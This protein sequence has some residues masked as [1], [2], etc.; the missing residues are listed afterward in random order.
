M[1]WLH[2]LWPGWDN[3][4]PNILADII[5]G[6]STAVWARRHFKRARARHDELHSTVQR[7]HE[8]LGVDNTE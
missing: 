1:L 8:H 5:V 7:I 4:W 2:H 6:L 3:V